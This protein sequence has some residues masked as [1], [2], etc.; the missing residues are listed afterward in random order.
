MTERVQFRIATIQFYRCLHDMA[1]EYLSV[2]QD[3]NSDHHG[4]IN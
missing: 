2:H 3:I 1:S 4:V